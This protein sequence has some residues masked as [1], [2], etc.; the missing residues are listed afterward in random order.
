MTLTGKTHS[1]NLP[2]STVD[3]GKIRKDFPIFSRLI[4]GKPLVYLD[5]TATTLKPAKVIEA[6]TGYYSRYT[7]NVFRGIY[8][9]SEEATAKFEESRGLVAGMIGADPAEIV[10]VRNASEALNVV[11][12][13]WAKTFLH[14][15]DEIIT[16]ILEHHSNFVPWQ[17]MALQ[18]KTGFRIWQSDPKGNLSL[19]DL[20][21]LVTKR[22]KLLAMTAVSNVTGTI[23]PVAGIVKRVREIN[24]GIKV[25]VD[26]AQAVPH[27]PVKVGD[28][29]ADFIAFS[30]HKMLGPTGIGV[31]WARRELLEV[32]PPYQYGGEM[33]REVHRDRTVFHDIPHK[34]EAGTPH[35]AGVIGLGAA[36]RYLTS[37]GMQSVRTH[38]Q[39][40]TTYALKR[41][42]QVPG[43]K[44]YGP[45]TADLRGGVIAFTLDGIHPHDTAQILDT[46]N[47]CVRVGFH[48]AQPLHEYL[49]CGP[50]VRASFYIYSTEDDIDALIK[51]IEKVKKVFG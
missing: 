11:Y 49:G 40:I 47:V 44:I 16:T 3:P 23:L 6:V 24:P 32:M 39:A 5:S 35:I 38:E 10:F 1:G 33:I 34:F 19:N 14:A 20:E 28:W 9:I 26:A 17:Q 43:L 50:T 29:N 30:G 7:A 15:G 4:N 37:L 46:D 13:S 45:E 21:S 51:G 18:S 41:L 2:P 12:S 36:V 31:L 27:M 48:C 22:T 25:L 8:A 42:Q